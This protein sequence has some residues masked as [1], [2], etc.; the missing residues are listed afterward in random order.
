MRLRPVI[1]HPKRVPKISEVKEFVC[2]FSKCSYVAIRKNPLRVILSGAKHLVFS[3]TRED[4]ILR[5]SA[6]DDSAKQLPKDGGEGTANFL[7][8]Q[9]ALFRHGRENRLFASLNNRNILS[10]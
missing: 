1:A 3:S 7:L 2:G 9:S 10:D 4:E 5:R 6:R 8:P